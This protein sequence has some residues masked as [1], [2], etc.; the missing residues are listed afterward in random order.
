MTAAD[1]MVAPAASGEA[2]SR[3]FETCVETLTEAHIDPYARLSRIEYGEAAP[4][5]QPAHL[6]WKFLDN[7]HGRSVG[8]HVYRGA[9]LVG[10]LVAMSR[11]FVHGGR[12]YTAAQFVDLLVHPD[13]RG[14]TPILRL[15]DGFRQLTGFDFVLMVSPNQPEITEAFFKVPP[16]F[17]LDVALVPLR[18]ARL[19]SGQGSF[20][21]DRVAPLIDWPWRLLMAGGAALGS[22]LCG[23]SLSMDWPDDRELGDL[24]A[25]RWDPEVVGERGLE[26]LDWRFRR[27]PIFKYDVRFIRRG[28]RLSG[29]LA[30]RRSVYRGYDCEFIVD[31]FSRRETGRKDAARATLS[32][33]R[34]A[35]LRGAE[36][37]MAVGNT[38]GGPLAA[39]TPLPFLK[40]PRRFRPRNTTVYA[41]WLSEPAFALDAA[42]L[43]L[44]LA[45]YDAF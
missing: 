43:H 24:L 10:R 29:Y 30:T 1:T 39:A 11:R 32:T 9:E 12:S 34:E 41:K 22:G 25:S 44:T 38:E 42:T 4:V 21:A 17:E 7:P 26:F 14:M 31:A 18:P 2:K 37:A 27:S 20:P 45:D 36:M 35:A 16:C 15:V 3:R 33:L 13:H 5:A 8:L 28:G 40:V 23:G 19:V 6:R